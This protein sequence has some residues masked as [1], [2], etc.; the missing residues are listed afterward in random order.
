MPWRAE[1]S[2]QK[3]DTGVVTS[4]TVEL[5][6]AVGAARTR[7]HTQ[8]RARKQDTSLVVIRYSHSITTICMFFPRTLTL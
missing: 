3:S 6:N 8:E 2:G 5:K 1:V 4:F 7:N